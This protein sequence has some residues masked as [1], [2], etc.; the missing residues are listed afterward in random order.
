MQINVSSSHNIDGTL[1][2]PL[3][4]GTDIVPEAHATGMHVAL[5]A[6]INRVLAD[7]DFKGKPKS[8]M[9]LVGSEGGKAML[10]GLGKEDDADVHAYRKAG[11]A[12]VAARKKTHG[13]DL[14]VRFA[15]A[16]IE[17]MGAFAEGMLL[18]DYSYDEYKMQKEEDKEAERSVRITCDE[19]QE[20]DLQAL[21]NIH[22]GVASG[23]H[24][25]RDL[26]NCPPNDMYPEAFSDMA[27]EWAKQ[28][29]NV[30]VT[31]INYEHA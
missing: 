16:S 7:G 1:I 18:R 9:S 23:V 2:L 5:K 11:A 14:T 20:E 30:D 12:V 29:D 25:S 27:W 6:Q 26:G 3:F 22:T 31:I 21:V 24:L 4:E 17:C 19:G 10:V 8:T 15:G 28:Y 13:T